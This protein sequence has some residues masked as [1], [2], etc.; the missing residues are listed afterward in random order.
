MIY[1]P[2]RTRDQALTEYPIIPEIEREEAELASSIHSAEPDES[3]YYR[4]VQ[5]KDFQEVPKSDGKPENRNIYYLNRI[6]TL[7]AYYE[8]KREIMKGGGGAQFYEGKLI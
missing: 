2:L 3:G 7:L 6:L 4:T 1:S 5:A 8:D